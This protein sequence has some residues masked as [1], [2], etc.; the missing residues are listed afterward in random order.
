MIDDSGIGKSDLVFTT[1]GITVNTVFTSLKS[2]PKIIPYNNVSYDDSVLKIGEEKYKS[3]VVNL[4]RL[5][6]LT[7]ELSEIVAARK[8]KTDTDYVTIENKEITYYLE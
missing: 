3:E 2:E 8:E 7:Q 5:Y 4:G 1:Q 6:D